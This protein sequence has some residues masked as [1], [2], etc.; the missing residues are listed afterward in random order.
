MS[1]TSKYS[2]PISDAQLAE[3]A[4]RRIDEIVDAAPGTMAVF[5]SYGL[6]MCCGGGRPLGEALELHGIEVDPVVRQIAAI[7]SESQDW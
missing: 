6:D 7:V 2:P 1:T 4:S 5:S 3:I